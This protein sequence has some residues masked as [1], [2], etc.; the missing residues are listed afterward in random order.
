[1]TEQSTQKEPLKRSNAGQIIP[2]GNC[3][4]VV[5]IFLGRDSDGKRQYQNQSIHGAKKKAQEWLTDALSK[6]DRGIPTFQTKVSVSDFLN[7]WLKTV[8]KPRVSE[9]TFRGYEWM[10]EH[11]KNAVGKTRLTQLRAEDIRGYTARF[12]RQRPGTS[13]RLSDRRCPRPSSGTSS[14]L[15]PAMRLTCPGTKRERSKRSR[16]KKL[17]GCWPLK[18]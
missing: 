11:V 17:A 5:R 9:Q 16:K 10:I 6:K 15:T 3:T 2:R 18:D 12:P 8:A 14:T 4:W 7:T 1:M 13:T